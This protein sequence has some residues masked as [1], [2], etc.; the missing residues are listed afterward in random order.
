MTLEK[1]VNILVE[2]YERAKKLTFVH[3]PLS[4]ALY[5][6]WK[7]VDMVE[8]DKEE[9]QNLRDTLTRIGKELNK[10]VTQYDRI[11]NMTAE[12]M[13]EA[14]RYRKCCPPN[15]NCNDHTSCKS[16]WLDYLDQE[17]EE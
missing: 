14:L 5:H 13:A 16:C 10:K 9:M 11:R 2:N 1:A 15:G 12:E 4:W 7:V 8:D 17:V 3:K 6:T